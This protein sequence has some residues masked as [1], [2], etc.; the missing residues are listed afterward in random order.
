M[1]GRML[2]K[3][4]DWAVVPGFSSLG[5]RA[6]DRLHPRGPLELK[7]RSVMVTG[8]SSGIGEAACVAIAREGAKVHLVVR[9]RE[10]GERSRERIASASG[11]EALELRLCDLS[12][13]ASVRE[14]ATGFAASGSPLH[15]SSTTPACCRR[16]GPYGGGLRA[17]VRDQCPRTLPADRVAPAP[18]APRRPLAGDQRLLGRDVHGEDPPRRPPARAARVRR[19]PVLRSYEA[20]RGDSQRGV[21]ET[22]GARQDHRPLGPSGV[23]GDP[24]SQASLPRFNRVMG[25]FLRDPAAGADTIVWLAG[26]RG[27]AR[28]SGDFWHDRRRG[29]AP[30]AVDPGERGGAPPLFDE[31]ERLCGLPPGGARL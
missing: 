1:L 16:A 19:R 20:S 27:A 7:G 4:M 25:P 3:A 31:C 18:P 22:L 5:Y 26:R 8:A 28:S 21:G 9:S 6:R 11:S 23:G 12:S 17:R 14:F 2:D 10:R 30:A 29:Q 13:L 24:G 15:S